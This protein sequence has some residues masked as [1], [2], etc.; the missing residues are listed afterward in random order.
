MKPFLRLLSRIGN[1]MAMAN[2]GNRSEFEK[3]M[4]MRREEDLAQA[5]TRKEHCASGKLSAKAA[6]DL[7]RTFDI[8]SSINTRKWTRKSMA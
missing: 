6:K 2:L 7:P 8:A 1:A 3:L 4:R 5:A